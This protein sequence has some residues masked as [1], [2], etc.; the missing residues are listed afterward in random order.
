MQGTR[1]RTQPRPR[2]HH[3]APRS[4]F[5]LVELLVTLG[6]IAIITAIVI[7]S[8]GRARDAAQNAV[9]VS[10]LRT[11]GTAWHAYVAERGHFPRT[12]RSIANSH[13]PELPPGAMSWGGAHSAS[14]NPGSPAL[15]VARPINAYVSAGH[16]SKTLLEIFHC[17]DDIGAKYLIGAEG[18]PIGESLPYQY[19]LHPEY[20]DTCLGVYGNSYYVNDWIWARV[21]SPDG[22]G[23]SGNPHWKFDNSLD[24]I[25]NP[26]RT[27]MLGDMGGLYPGAFT[28][29]Q[30]RTLFIPVGWWHGHRQSNVV[31]W[32]GSVRRVTMVPGGY[33]SDYWLWLQ[34][35]EH[36]EWGTPIAG[37]PSGAR[38]P[39]SQ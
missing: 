33:T 30:H 20:L 19:F 11:L 2:R 29:E 5:S 8:L 18:M 10:N 1:S 25:I 16:L 24:A 14:S 13:L 35:S 23:P 21:G 26:S 28:D 34:P 37:V 32:D 4:A 22:G 12:P 15:D 17:P 38:P 9:C 39:A 6:V 3:G 27:V 31:M 7:P 36:P